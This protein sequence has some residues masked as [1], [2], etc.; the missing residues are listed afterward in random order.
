MSHP[1]PANADSLTPTPEPGRF[2]GLN[3]LFDR[4]D[5]HFVAELLRRTSGATFLA[6]PSE[7]VLPAPGRSC[8]PSYLA[9]RDLGNEAGKIVMQYGEA[10]WAELVDACQEGKIHFPNDPS[11]LPAESQARLRILLADLWFWKLH[12]RCIPMPDPTTIPNAQAALEEVAE[13]RKGNASF[14]RHV[15]AG[16]W[17]K[18]EVF[19]G[20]AVIYGQRL[21]VTPLG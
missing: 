17:P 10:A 8:P 13:L 6:V 5:Y 15:A 11:D 3:I 18:V 21:E 20:I 2:L 9:M 19:G 1:A 14:H 7:G 16:G 12:T 4:H